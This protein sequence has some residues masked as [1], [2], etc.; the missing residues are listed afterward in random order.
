[1]RRLCCD[2]LTLIL[3]GIVEETGDSGGLA[4]KARDISRTI[5][6]CDIGNKQTLTDTLSRKLLDNW[7]LLILPLALISRLF[8]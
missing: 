3:E 1:M 6:R 8:F 5:A 7:V 2:G 4:A